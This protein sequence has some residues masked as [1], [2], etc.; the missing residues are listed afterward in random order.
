M[1]NLFILLI[2][3]SSVALQAQDRLFTYTY[4]SNVLN[5]GQKE[6]EVWTTM[7]NER[8]KY[9]RALDHSLEFELGLGSKLQTSFYLNYGYAKGIDTS[10][11]IETIEVENNYS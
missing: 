9:Y 10:N 7:H 11:G 3:T 6:I 1:K 4:Q 2:L 8:E 5:K